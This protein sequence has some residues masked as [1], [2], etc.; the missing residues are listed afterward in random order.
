M[1]LLMKFVI[2]HISNN[3]VVR[4]RVSN[5]YI[6]LLYFRVSCATLKKNMTFV[7][8]TRKSKNQPAPLKKIIRKLKKLEEA[9][10]GIAFFSQ[11]TKIMLNVIRVCD[12]HI[13]HDVVQSWC[14]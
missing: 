7:F 12:K 4:F 1:K 9:I 10:K 11:G 14:L 2:Y 13:S 3:S 6:L 5:Y 8:A